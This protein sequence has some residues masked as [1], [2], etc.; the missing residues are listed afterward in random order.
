[1]GRPNAFTMV[2]GIVIAVIG[3]VLLLNNFGATRIDVGEFIESYWPLILVLW[4]LSVILQ[5]REERGGGDVG[6]W[7]VLIIG[8]LLLGR[9]TGFYRFDLRWVWGV[10]WPV[11]IILIGLNLLRSSTTRGDTRWGVM[12]VT[13]LKN[14]GWELKDGA[15]VAFMG[16]VNMDLT[17]ADIPDREVFLDLTA[18]MGGMDIKAPRDL[19]IECEGTAV[20]GGVDFFRESTGGVISSRRFSQRGPEGSPKKVIIRCRAIMGGIEIKGD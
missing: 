4:G 16:G 5:P 15:Y 13:E 2:M 1:M 3:I 8:L 19:A 6:A 18:V 12:S 17:V 7:I 20:L 10:F 9:T 11:V 14:D